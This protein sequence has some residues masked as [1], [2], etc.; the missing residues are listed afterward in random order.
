MPLSPSD[1]PVFSPAHHY[2][3][4]L[5]RATCCCAQAAPQADCLGEDFGNCR[6]QL[7]PLAALQWY[8][9]T[10]PKGTA[11]KAVLFLWATAPWTDAII[12]LHSTKSQFTY[13]LDIQLVPSAC[14]W[15]HITRP[16]R[17]EPAAS[18]RSH[19]CSTHRAVAGPLNGTG[20]QPTGWLMVS[21][22]S[23]RAG[24]RQHGTRVLLDLPCPGP[25]SLLKPR[26][27]T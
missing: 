15:L 21:E 9:K 24:A 6:A 4:H 3:I 22:G 16:P 7:Q 10:L 5:L 11:P 26:G 17:E 23:G 19:C 13:R 18:P 14:R 27:G 20:Q 12:Q 1:Q 2:A 25:L 8:L